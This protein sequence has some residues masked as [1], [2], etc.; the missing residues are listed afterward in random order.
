[1]LEEGSGKEGSEDKGHTGI[2][3]QHPRPRGG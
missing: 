2:E 3:E 1:M